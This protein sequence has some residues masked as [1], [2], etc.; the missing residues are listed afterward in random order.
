MEATSPISGAPKRNSPPK[1]NTA[2]LT[3]AATDHAPTLTVPLRFIVTG[4][5]ALSTAA[6]WLVAEPTLITNYH[7]SPH[8][9]AFAHLVL[10]GFLASVVMGVVYQLAPVAFETSLY[11]QR[12]GRVQFWFHVVGFTGMVWMFSHWDIKQVGHF[13]SI[14][15]AGVLL[16]AYN[17]VRT[18]LRLPKWNVIACGVTSAV[19]WLVVTMLAGLFLA[20]AK[21]WPQI[22][23][24]EP[25]AQM[26][27]HAHLGGMGVFVMLTVS[28]AYRLVPMFSVS[29]IQSMG[30]AVS[31]IVLLNVSVAGLAVTILLRSPWK[32]AF[33]SLGVLALALFAVE[34]FSILAAR[35]RR[36]LDWGLRYF[37]TGTAFLVPLSG[38][39]MVLSWPGLRE[40][41]VT[42]QLEN[43]YAI[44]ALFGVLCFAILGM[45]YKILPFLVW[46][47]RYGPFVG[48]GRVPSLAD[49]L[50]Q[51]IQ[52]A[53]Y[54][55]HVLGVLIASAASVLGHT[56]CARMAAALIAVSVFLFAINSFHILS[57]L[58][59]SDTDES[60]HPAHPARASA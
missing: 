23:P 1:V 19:G 35:K 8:A 6:G 16:F 9:V 3:A 57:H 4:L 46:F 31:S 41:H 15:G 27:A 11:S 39:G 53:G 10:L 5:L 26:H 58:L 7:Y 43:A 24:F 47:H 18:L 38:V 30:R 42:L 48:R 22:S 21:C 14:F 36:T 52:V 59:R 25:L 51:R 54:Y 32:I 13:G 56:R 37:L 12:L 17:I 20:C 29:K 60:P 55:L 28:V 34:L 50:S 44:L 45:L 33:A 2:R 49:M 40:T